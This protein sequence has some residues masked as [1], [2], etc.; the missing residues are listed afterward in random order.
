MLLRSLTKMFAIPG[1][2]L[3]YAMGNPEI[4]SKTSRLSIALER[5]CVALEAGSLCFEEENYPDVTTELI[6]NSNVKSYL[7]STVNMVSI[8]SLSQVNFYLLR[9][10]G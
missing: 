9:D 8:Y 2:R 3:G 6:R 1:L 7:I 4:D 10:H 5:K